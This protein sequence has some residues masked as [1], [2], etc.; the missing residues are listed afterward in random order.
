MP[1]TKKTETA[2]KSKQEVTTAEKPNKNDGLIALKHFAKSGKLFIDGEAYD[3]VDG[4]VN[5]KPE[6][7]IKAEEHIK[8]MGG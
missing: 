5:V 1:R 7:Y 4:V 3:V 6:H 8:L 2:E